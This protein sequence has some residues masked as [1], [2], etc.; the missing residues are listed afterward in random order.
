MGCGRAAGAAIRCAALA[1]TLAA[2]GRGAPQPLLAG[3]PGTVLFYRP[4][5]PLRGFVFLFSAT[6]GWT[7]AVG[8]AATALAGRG[9]A[10][11]GVDL[12]QYLRNLA[13]SDDGFHYVIAE[14][15]ET[16]QRLQ[17]ELAAPRY[18]SPVLAGIGAG[19]T[20]AY[21][22][23]AQAPAATV[24]GAVSIDP[25][26]ALPTRV[27]SGTGRCAVFPAGGR[28]SRPSR[29]PTGWPC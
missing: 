1:V 16:S 8:T 23:L 10:V 14:L 27:A 18:H 22:A 29:S 28:S 4:A 2:C 19:G 20:L 5:G 12:G 3:R 9:A 25:V 17:R 26:A 13:A 21:A 11:V 15:E 6:A 24:L 7:P